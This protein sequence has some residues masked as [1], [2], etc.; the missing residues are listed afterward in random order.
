MWYMEGDGYHT[1][2]INEFMQLITE[3]ARRFIF[4]VLLTLTILV[5]YHN[6]MIKEHHSIY[7]KSS[8]Y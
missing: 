5:M 3:W 8:V 2:I 7:W 4:V 1:V 6:K